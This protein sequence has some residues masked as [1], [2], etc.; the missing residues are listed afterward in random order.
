M[1]DA[2]SS[3]VQH[4][5]SVEFLLLHDITSILSSSLN[6]KDSLSAIFDLLN[7]KLGLKRSVLTL[8]HPLKESPQI[9]MAHGI[10]QLDMNRSVFV[11]WSDITSFVLKNRAACIVNTKGEQAVLGKHIPEQ[12]AQSEYICLPVFLGEESFG[13]LSI[14]GDFVFKSN[15]CQILNLFFILCLMIAQEIKLK[16][17]LDLEKQDLRQENSTLRKELKGKY[18]IDNM[19]G[20]SNAMIS[21]YESITQ[22]ANSNATVLIYGESGTGKELVA[23]A[24][25]YRSSR[26]NHPFIKINCGAIPESLIESELFGYEK[27]AFTDAYERRIGKFEA[28]HLGTVF[29]DEVGEL[30]LSMQVKLLRVI[31]ERE[32]VRVGG[33]EPVKVNVRVIAATNRDLESEMRR[34]AFRQDLYY[35]L[36]VF[37][38]FIPPL[39]DRASDILLLAEH[40]LQ[41]YAKENEHEDM[42][43]SPKTIDLLL[44]YPWPGNVRE[45][46]NC[47]ERAVLVCDSTLVLPVHLPQTL[48][49]EGVVLQDKQ[50]DSLED[51]VQ[52]YEKNI[53]VNALMLSKGNQLNAAQLL[54]TTQRIIGYKIKNYGID[55]TLFK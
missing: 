16:R 25:H 28:A 26:I 40:F 18:S 49:W 23:H 37:P 35:R 52:T 8:V 13:T 27:G 41:K 15:F 29:L 38:I 53:I 12:L 6:L 43:F 54:K 47:M 36:N 42:S 14:H 3:D 19:I 5:D 4:S 24:I 31:Q 2:F 32:F 20:Q 34:G 51:L 30:P 44:R 33:V 46:E 7:E 22:V 11:M 45:L 48:H 21:V 1:V 9:E 55:P 39:R 17:I 50:Q 10:T